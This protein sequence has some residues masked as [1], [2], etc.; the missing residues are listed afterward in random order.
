MPQKGTKER[1]KGRGHLGFVFLLLCALVIVVAINPAILSRVADG[2]DD[3]LRGLDQRVSQN[4]IG[5]ADLGANFILKCPKL[6]H[7]R[8]HIPLIQRG[9]TCV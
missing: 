3:R 8:M 9:R 4:R 2:I 1:K 6:A 7:G 5:S